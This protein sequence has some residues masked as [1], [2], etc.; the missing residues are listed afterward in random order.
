MDPEKEKEF[1]DQ[2][3]LMWQKLANLSSSVSVFTPEQLKAIQEVSSLND[4]YI[5]GW[6]EFALLSKAT[7]QWLRKNFVQFWQI[8][9]TLM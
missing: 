9:G 8:H 5:T 2:Y 1:L 6:K 3:P 7:P 4:I